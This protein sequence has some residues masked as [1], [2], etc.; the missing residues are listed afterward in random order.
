MA[1]NALFMALVPLPGCYNK[2]VQGLET[3]MTRAVVFPFDSF[4]SP[5]T[6]AGAMA[7][8]DALREMRADF[9]RETVPTRA[10]SWAEDLKIR[11]VAF[12]TPREI[13]NFRRTGRSMARKPLANGEPLVWLSGNHLG[14]LPLL[15]LAAADT[16]TLVIQ[17]DAHLDIH[18]FGDSV[19]T[20][21]HGNY[22]RRLRWQ[23]DGLPRLIHLG[24]RDLLQKPDE[25][26]TFIPTAISAEEMAGDINGTRGRLAAMAAEHTKIVIDIDMDVF[27]EGIVPGMARPVPCGLAPLQLWHVLKALNPDRVVALALS[28]YDPDRDDRDRGLAVLAWFMERF[29]LWKSGG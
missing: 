28:E 8:G 26:E 25:I 12:D 15:D 4:G 6:S 13:A 14:V 3:A 21:S 1:A 20:L 17:A 23:P 16:D 7:M 11:E 10:S 27:D 22:L 24:H 29:L 5:G 19:E 9:H 18:A 2:P